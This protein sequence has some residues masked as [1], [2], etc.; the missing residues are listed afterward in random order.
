M[1]IHRERI[2]KIICLV[3]SWIKA[4]RY[5]RGGYHSFRR[6]VVTQLRDIEK[7]DLALQKYMKWSGSLQSKMLNRYT[8]IESCL[9]SDNI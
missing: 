3:D 2:L 8:Q 5:I 1:I 6:R 4:V 9:T 7:S